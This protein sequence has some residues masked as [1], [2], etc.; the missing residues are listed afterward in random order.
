MVGRLG[1][2]WTMEGRLEWTMDDRLEWTID[3]RPWTMEGR[4]EWTIDHICPPTRRLAR[5]QAGIM[6]GRR[7]YMD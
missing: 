5:W 4:L 2:P 1:G 6:E 3:H 7:K